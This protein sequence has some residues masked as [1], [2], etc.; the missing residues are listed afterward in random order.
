MVRVRD[1]FREHVKFVVKNGASTHFWLDWWSGN[2]P[3]ASYFMVLFSYCSNPEI[4]ISEL[5]RNNWDLGFRRSLSPK[6][7]GD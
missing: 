4:S 7:L 6:E 1:V 5:S 2:T 3:L